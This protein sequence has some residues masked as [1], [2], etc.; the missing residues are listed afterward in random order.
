MNESAYRLHRVHFHIFTS[1]DVDNRG[2]AE[3]GG[4]GRHA[5]EAQQFSAPGKHSS[6]LHV[7]T[8]RW[9]ARG[10]G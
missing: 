9:R 5:T 6:P 1:W 4:V 3:G 2:L 7:V 10:G 8:L